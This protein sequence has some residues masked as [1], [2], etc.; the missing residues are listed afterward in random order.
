[1]ASARGPNRNRP[2]PPSDIALALR[3]MPPSGANSRR[4]ST[5]STT[6]STTHSRPTGSTLNASAGMKQQIL[7]IGMNPGPFG[8]VQ[9]GVPFGEVSAVRDWLDI[10]GGVNPPPSQHP[11]RQVEG[12]SCSRSEV[13]GQRLWGWARKRFGTPEAFFQRFFV[14]NYCPLAFLEESGRNRTPNRL[15]Q[16]E[17]TPLYEACDQG[18]GRHGA[19][20]GTGPDPGHRP[21]RRGTGPSSIGRYSTHRPHPASES[22]QS[23]RQPRLGGPGGSTAGRPRRRTALTAHV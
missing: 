20:S 5:T 12:F 16:R 15:P 14:W 22:R 13:S 21:L 4:L 17:R 9:T 3:R 10:T 2:F 19:L 23:G 6:R 11:K 8:M 18:F 7:L 1:M